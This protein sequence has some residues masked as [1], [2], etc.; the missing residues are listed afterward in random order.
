MSFQN[1][2][3]QGPMT[4]ARGIGSIV[5]GILYFAMSYVVIVFQNEGKIQIGQTFSYIA[6][7]FLIF[8]GIFRIYRGWNMLKNAE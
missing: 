3:P 2:R 1:N 5:M 4:K 7:G 6:A 8:Y